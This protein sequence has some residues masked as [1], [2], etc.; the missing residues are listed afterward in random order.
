V[1]KSIKEGEKSRMCNTQ[2]RSY[3]HTELVRNLEN[4]GIEGESTAK[5]HI[6]GIGCEIDW[7]YIAQ[8]MTQFWFVV[9]MIVNYE[10]PQKAANFM[11]MGVT[12]SLSRTVLHGIKCVMKHLK[13]D[14]CWYK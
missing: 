3:I 4:L 12:I 13:V 1:I 14:L 7:I 9:N 11:T 2:A 5:M 6:K 10:V 8:E